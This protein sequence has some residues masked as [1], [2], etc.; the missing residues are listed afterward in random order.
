MGNIYEDENGESCD[1]LFQNSLLRTVVSDD[2]Q[3][4]R[5]ICYDIADSLEITAEKHFRTF[6]TYRFVYDFTP[7]SLS[8]IRSLADPEYSRRF[9]I[10]RNGTN[11][12]ADG[13][14]DAGAYEG[15]YQP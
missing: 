9:P 2:E 13:L 10:D 4:F 14:P 12:M 3:R 8:A 5:N 7:D 11:R 6:D 15:V 1:Y